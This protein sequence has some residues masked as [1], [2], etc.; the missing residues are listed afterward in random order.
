MKSQPTTHESPSIPLGFS[1]T[2]RRSPHLQAPLVGNAAPEFSA[3]AVYDQ[4]FID[5][6][7]SQFK[8]RACMRI[9]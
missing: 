4:E 1:P 7:L 8:V 6:N 3:T 2:T 5:L 9:A